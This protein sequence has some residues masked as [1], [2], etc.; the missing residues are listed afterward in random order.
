VN[1]AEL[2]RRTGLSRFKLRT[3]KKNG[4]TVKAHGLVGRK[5]ETTV[6]SG[7]TGVIDDL[8]RDG[9]K[10]SVVC[11][12]RIREQGYRGSQTVVRDYVRKHQHLLPPKRQLIAPQGN[13]GRRYETGPGESFQMD[14]G[15]VEV[16]NGMGCSYK[17]ACFA[18]IC[19]HCGER[20]VEFFP[21][22]KQENLFIG[23]IH[24]FIYLG[25]P[26]YVLTDNVKSVVARRD[27]EGHPIWQRDYETFMKT[28]G[29]ETKLCKPLHP[30]TKG[31]IE[32]LIRF[33]KENFLVGRVFGTITDLNYEA[34]RWCANQNGRYH[35]AV[36]CTPD[37]KHQISCRKIAQ[38]VVKT[39]EQT[40][41][42]SVPG[43]ID[44]VRWIREL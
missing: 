14:W 39:R 27:P 17:V 5:A 44:I 42:L 3:L 30:F 25:I 21:N 31:K 26:K 28:V 1:L 20:Y 11:Y 40:G 12:D 33:V 15:F 43:T 23:M 36:D 38:I 34:L 10:N 2:A 18:M 7:Y 37:D 29:F 35:R 4:F 6:L 24:A 13:R 8:L 16:V 19:H 32:R 22:A 9:V 41:L